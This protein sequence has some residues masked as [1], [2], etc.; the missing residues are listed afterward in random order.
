MSRAYAKP[1]NDNL[2]VAMEDIVP[3]EH[4][5]S[6]LFLDI[7]TWNIRYFH[8]RDEER[9]E[10]ISHI[11][12][13]LN[14]DIFVLEEILDGSLEVV[15]QKLKEL[16]SGHYLIRYGKTGADQRIAMMYD[17]DWVR[18]KDDVG[19]LFADNP[20]VDI[21]GREKKIF[22]RLP[23]W[24]YFTCLTQSNIPPFDFQLIGVHLKSQRED[25]EDG[26]SKKQR[27]SAANMLASWMT[28][29]AQDVDADVIATGDWNETPDSDTWDAFH[30]LE[31][32]DALV[33]SKLNHNNE[34]S[35]LMYKN[36]NDIGSRLDLTSVSMAS[37]KRLVDRKAEVVR[38]KS[39]DSVLRVNPK[40]DELR[41]F[42]RE[43][44][45]DISDHMPVITRFYFEV[46]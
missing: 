26:A 32:D 10:K 35:H 9:V 5:G 3:V 44:S 19:E 18:A 45:H 31:K 17:I 7:V 11:L 13:A 27:N 33:F 21:G 30:K 2:S 23:L 24:G 39:L 22:P 34:I 14:A 15:S 37:E 41:Q 4:R 8:D 28:G 12:N 46:K 42:I 16:K 40:A 38:W 43:I 29:K 25:G 36:K 1:D 20:K 6:P